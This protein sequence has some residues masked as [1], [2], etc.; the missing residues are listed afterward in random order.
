M[1]NEDKYLKKAKMKH[2]HF[3]TLKEMERLIETGYGE[4]S[5]RNNVDKYTIHNGKLQT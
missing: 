5:F 3:N 2:F 1:L 4:R